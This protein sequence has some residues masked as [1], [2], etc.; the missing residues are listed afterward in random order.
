MAP[1]SEEDS[2]ANA[3]EGNHSAVRRLHSAQSTGMESSVFRFQNVNFT[4]GKGEDKKN[5]LQDISAVVKWGH[6]LAIMGPSGA[7]KTTVISALTLDALYGNTTGTV[8]LNGVPM[9]DKIFK[10]HS[11]VVV[12]LDKHWP[13]LTCRET[14]IFA[15]E[16]YDIAAKEDLGPLVDETIAKMGLTVC[17]DTRNARLSGGQARRLSIAIA[18]L[19][20]PT[21][22]FL[23]EP[24]TGL[25]AAA[26]ENIMKEIVRVAK[27]ERIIILCTIHQPSTKVYNGFDQVMILSKGRE[28]FTG[29]VTDATGYFESIGYP[30]PVQTNPAEH[31]LDLVNSD[32]SDDA[33]VDKILN[34]WEEQKPEAG[35]S[36][37]KKGF[38]ENEETGVTDL[39]RASLAKE[40]SIMF[41]RCLTLIIRDPI[42]YVGRAVM[43]LIANT[44][45]SLVYLKART[46][47]QDQALNKMW[48]TIWHIAVTSNMGVVA[49]YALNDEFKT[50]LRENKNGMVGPLS[51]VLAKTILVIPIML[52]FGVFALGIPTI[53]IMDFPGSAF[54]M[55]LLL[56]SSSLLVF[57]CVAESLS[58]WFDD[59]ILG[60]LQFM[61]FWF[62]CFLFAGF[63]IPLRDMFWPFELFYYIMP[64]SYY[65][66]S[67]MYNLLHET[68]W[69]PCNTVENPDE[70][71]CVTPPTG[72]NVLGALTGVY[73]VIEDEDRVVQDLGT[74]LAI[75]V[76]WKMTYIAGVIY[77]SSQVSKIH[78]A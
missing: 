15:A 18:L 73:A 31:F 42:L 53:V 12:Q 13:Y 43:F 22:L 48:I 58:V 2:D 29:N 51:Y 32:F 56:W 75:A 64:Y 8:K 4:V 74:I 19:K 38:D 45:F 72:T 23:D 37:H 63:L 20:Q 61:N 76:F 66:R 6:V 16:L 54:G 10:T 24:T 52:I 46:Y 39:K 14:L 50:I 35:S 7:G 62:G 5:I 49:V 30:L 67:Q 34:T 77:K 1:P 40:I 21:L 59:P 3:T 69:E 44:F 33:E 57:E 26:S 25:D 11:Y 68:T 28:A 71:V 41:R 9:T 47:D 78:V 27:E 55:G 36:H 60:M 65:V 70:P 17:A